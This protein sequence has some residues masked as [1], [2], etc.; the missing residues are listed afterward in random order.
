MIIGIDMDDVLV[1]YVKSFLDFYNK[2]NKTDLSYEEFTSINKSVDKDNSFFKSDFFRKMEICGGAVKAIKKLAEKNN[3]FIVTSRQI[4][5]KR[6]TEKFIEENFPGCFRGIFFAEDIH[7]GTGKKKS[8]IYEGMDMIIEDNRSHAL[9]CAKNGI[10]VFLLDKPWNRDL[11]HINIIRVK[12]WNEII[13][14][15]FKKE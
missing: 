10:K 13:S 12:G 6:N 1:E 15:I 7:K 4:E 2:R 8:D 11:E 5:W 3:L 14:L 9:E